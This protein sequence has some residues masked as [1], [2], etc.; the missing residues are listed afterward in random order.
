MEGKKRG[1]RE[2]GSQSMRRFG[3]GERSR[4]SKR[5]EGTRID[6]VEVERT[7]GMTAASSVGRLGYCF[8]V[9]VELGGEWR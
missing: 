2:R 3:G 9:R 8:S 7:V 6:D 5:F 4:P 1:G